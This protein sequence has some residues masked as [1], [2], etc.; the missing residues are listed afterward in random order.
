MLVVVVV[1][2]MMMM[3]LLAQDGGHEVPDQRTGRLARNDTSSKVLLW[4]EGPWRPRD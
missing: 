4:R 3:M 1:V 2:M